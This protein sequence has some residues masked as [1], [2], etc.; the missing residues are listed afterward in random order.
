MVHHK[1]QKMKPPVSKKELLHSSQRCSH[2]ENGQNFH[3]MLC[4]ITTASSSLIWRIQ[5]PIIIRKTNCWRRRRLRR[6]QQQ[7]ILLWNSLARSGK[8]WYW[9]RSESAA[10]IIKEVCIHQLLLLPLLQQQQQQL[11]IKLD[12]DAWWDPP[13]LDESYQ[14]PTTKT[15]NSLTLPTTISTAITETQKTIL[16]EAIRQGSSS[17]SMIALLRIMCLSA[18]RDPQHLYPDS[19]ANHEEQLYEAKTML[20]LSAGEDDHALWIRV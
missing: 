18:I 14:N 17:S 5:L 9:W 7:Q 15:T 16:L 3:M 2:I 11:I 6:Q 20:L 1:L 13:T 12:D 4:N 10:S 19:S 8:T